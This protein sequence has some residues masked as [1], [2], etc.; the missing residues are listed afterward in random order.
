M[1]VNS[2]PGPMLKSC[3]YAMSGPSHHGSPWSGVLHN[4][5]A[6]KYVFI[7]TFTIIFFLSLSILTVFGF[8]PTSSQFKNIILPKDTIS[9]GP[10]VPKGE[11]EMPIRIEI[12][13]IGLRANVSNPT[14]TDVASLDRALLT[15][16]VRYP[17]SGV[18]GEEGNVLMFGH[19]SYLPVVHN[20]A[21]KAFNDIQKLKEGDPI[22]V[23]GEKKVYI[24]A[25][26]KVEESNT[27]TG[28]IPLAISGS[29]LTLATCDTFGAKSDRFIVTANLVRV[30]D[31]EVAE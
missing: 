13:E 20:Q 21:Y 4:I 16:A 31:V 26:E 25:V 10:R 19:S 24:Y 27:A 7:G 8:A 14:A 5:F 23:L 12:P 17:G 29:K 1:F 30:Q 22:F 15:G 18:P 2:L 11:G 28:E 3:T 9:D 6:R